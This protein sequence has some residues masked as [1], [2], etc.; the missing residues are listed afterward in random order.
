VRKRLSAFA[1]QLGFR[2]SRPCVKVI[3]GTLHPCFDYPYDKYTTF[4]ATLP[5]REDIGVS[6]D[7]LLL[8]YNKVISVVQYEG[9]DPIGGYYRAIRLNYDPYYAW[10]NINALV[11][12]PVYVP[13]AQAHHST[14]SASVGIFFRHACFKATNL[15]GM[16]RCDSAQS[17]SLRNLAKCWQWP[18]YRYPGLLIELVDHDIDRSNDPVAR[19]LPHR[20]YIDIKAFEP[21]EDGPMLKWADPYC[22]ACFIYLL[23]RDWWGG[24]RI[25]YGIKFEPGQTYDR[26]PHLYDLD[27]PIDKEACEEVFVEVPNA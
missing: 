24:G 27:V 3:S 4:I 8:L 23:Y 1:H 12:F 15:Y 21:K 13:D 2:K 22:V 6:K 26:I 10:N 25:V 5:G 18:P 19:G 20:L 11:I 9:T 16:A 7:K 14:I 17:I